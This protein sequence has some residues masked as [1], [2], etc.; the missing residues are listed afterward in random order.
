MK[1]ITKFITGITGF[2]LLIFIV[3]CSSSKTSDPTIY[4]ISFTS[5]LED[6]I[7]IMPKTCY[8]TPAS[9]NGLSGNVYSVTGTV[10]SV[11]SDTESQTGTE[12]FS[13]KSDNGTAW[14]GV[15]GPEYFAEVSG[16]DIKTFAELMDSTMD[17]TLPKEGDY[18]T[19][20]G[21]Y[22]GYS[23][24]LDAPFLY[25]GIDE[26]VYNIANE[27]DEKSS[28]NTTPTNTPTP[29]P[30]VNPLEDY[31]TVTYD[32]VIS[33]NYNEQHVCV[34][35][36]IDK[37]NNRS[38]SSCSFALWYSSSNGYIYDATVNHT[39]YEIKDGSVESIF[40]NAQ[41][42]DII[43]FATQIKGNGIGTSDIEAAQI[44]GSSNL[45]EIHNSYKSNCPDMNYE[46]IQRNPDTYKG[47]HFKISGTVFQV[48]NE[49]PTSAEYLISTDYGYIYAS[50]YSDEAVRGSRFLED[51]FVTIYGE[52]L[53]LKSYDTLVGQNTVP[54]I[55]VSFMELN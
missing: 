40:A 26:F 36:V 39:F 20:Y 49:S 2:A 30:T 11:L 18:V 33:G 47:S 54:Q 5:S 7:T 41:N 42:G 55:S 24:V 22:S 29:L 16:G 34:E 15:L 28:E 37:I 10:D 6:Q 21:I 31:P 32:D 23:D 46:D 13:V 52:F 35:A 44:T 27:S 48:I 12:T 3:G 38:S 45:D 53:I 17:Y 14:F 8:N 43:K 1:K 9:E 4:P 19:V 25:F 51:D 50:W